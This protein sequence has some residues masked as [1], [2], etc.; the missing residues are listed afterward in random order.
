MDPRLRIAFTLHA[1]D[2]AGVLGVA[3]VGLVGVPARL[4][5]E[6]GVEGEA[7]G[8][9]LDAETDVDRARFTGTERDLAEAIDPGR[10][11][12]RHLRGAGALD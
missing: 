4:A 3:A 8:E 2:G 9:V 10:F 1:V 12:L 7:E 5:A 11:L 6:G